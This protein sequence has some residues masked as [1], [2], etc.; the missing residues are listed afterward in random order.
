[1][2]EKQK[3]Y[4]ILHRAYEFDDIGYPNLVPTKFFISKEKRDKA[5]EE[6]VAK[7]LQWF[8]KR[9]ADHLKYYGSFS[10]ED[11]YFVNVNDGDTLELFMGE[12][13][14]EWGKEEY[15]IEE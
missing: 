4:V 9:K 6:I 5:F 3:I 14:Y 12:W 15:E 11:E 10:T 7:E 8:E 2:I 1:M 13:C